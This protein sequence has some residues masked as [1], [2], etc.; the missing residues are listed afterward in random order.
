MKKISILF[1]LFCLL[2][3]NVYAEGEEEPTPEPTPEVDLIGPNIEAPSGILI[4]EETGTI[5]AKKDPTMHVPTS[6]LTKT[7][8][9]YLACENLKDEEE[10]TMSTEAFNSYDHRA[11]VIWVMDGESIPAIDLEHAALMQNANDCMAMLAEGVSGSAESFLNKMNET[12]QELGM[13]NTYYQNIFG[14]HD[15]NNYTCAE[16][17]AI[18]TRKALRN[19]TFRSAYS[20]SSYR[21]A[22]TAMQVNERLLAAN[23]EMI[24]SGDDH[25][26][27]AVGCEVGYTQEGGYTL[28]V[29]AK[30]GETSFIAVVLGGSSEK[31][32]YQDAK[33]LIEYGFSQY[34]TVTITPE[35]I[36]TKEIEVYDG[37]KHVADV[38]FSVDTAFKALLPTTI[39]PKS[40]VVEINTKNEDSSNPDDIQA[41]VLFMLDGKQVGSSEMKKEVRTIGVS[42]VQKERSMFYVVIDWISV[43]VLG[44]IVLR[45]LGKILQPNAKH[46]KEES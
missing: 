19:D 32:V 36:G 26:E 1:L 2:P 6:G 9:V 27:S 3:M 41:E 44:L 37:N 20:S 29:E 34:Q 46:L 39:D 14:L 18:L 22:P 45:Q 40:L 17:L 31:G 13:A 43:A 42:A 4:D 35:D 10:V 21:I 5:L 38:V 15:E 7:M 30:R 24:R 23:C 25:Y 12:A 8:G 16:D 28:T 33:T 11:S